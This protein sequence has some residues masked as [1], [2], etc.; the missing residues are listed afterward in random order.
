MSQKQDIS[1]TRDYGLCWRTW[2]VVQSRKDRPHNGSSP[3]EK[4]EESKDDDDW[5][6]GE[7]RGRSFSLYG[8]VYICVSAILG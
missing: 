2:Y 5:G 7:K 1:Q 8:R 6:H 3:I 4:D